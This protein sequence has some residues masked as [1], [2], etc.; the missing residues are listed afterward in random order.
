MR[1]EERVRCS[2][3][4]NPG[5][6]PKLT[7]G[8]SNVQCLSEG[9]GG[10]SIATPHVHTLFLSGVLAIWVDQVLVPQTK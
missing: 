4:V 5:L 9:T 3:H 7:Q 1:L 6:M 8:H 10:K 2:L